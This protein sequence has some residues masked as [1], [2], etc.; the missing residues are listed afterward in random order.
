MLCGGVFGVDWNRSAIFPSFRSGAYASQLPFVCQ[1]SMLCSIKIGTV[2]AG[3]SM[4]GKVGARK[5]NVPGEIRFHHRP[6]SWCV[7]VRGCV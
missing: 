7:L 4:S 5:P 2:V 3:L 6:D 1:I